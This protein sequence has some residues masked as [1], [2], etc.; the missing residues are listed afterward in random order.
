[1]VMHDP[2]KPSTRKNSQILEIQDDGGRRLEKSKNGN[3]SATVWLIAKF[4]TSTIMNCA[5][6][7]TAMIPQQD[8]FLDVTTW[9]Y[10]YYDWS[11]EYR[12]RLFPWYLT[13]ALYL[14]KTKRL[15]GI[16]SGFAHA[17]NNVRNDHL[18]VLKTDKIS[19]KSQL[20][21]RSSRCYLLIY[22]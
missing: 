19:D 1:M 20:H 22:I 4:G 12:L 10:F 15:N 7:I 6:E 18:C 9:P 11:A 21:K 14:F 17:L 13:N 3:I 8:L 2:L 5:A 16:P